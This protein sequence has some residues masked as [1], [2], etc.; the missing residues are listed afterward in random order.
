MRI[1]FDEEFA[2]SIEEV[3]DYFRT[4]A[5]WVRLYGSAGRVEDRGDGW[6]AVPLQKFPFPLVAKVTEFEENRFVRWIF[7]GFWHGSC[8]VVFVDTPRGV[9]IRG[10]EDITPRGLG[11]LAN[12]FEKLYLERNFR[13][14][15]E[16]G[17]RRLRKAE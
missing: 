4:P 10:Y 9:A 1:E 2:L 17:W 14:I 15:W 8:E 3:F 7:R 13:A 12:P 5:D 16:L 11:F 6:L